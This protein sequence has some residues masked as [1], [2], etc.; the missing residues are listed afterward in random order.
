ME[1]RD[2]KW[3]G[4]AIESRHDGALRPQASGYGASGAQVQAAGHDSPIA[5]EG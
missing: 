4:T 3:G 1:A 2:D 5:S